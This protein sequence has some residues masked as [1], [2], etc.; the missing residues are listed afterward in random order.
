MRSN[1]V[2]RVKD[3]FGLTVNYRQYNN[4]AHWQNVGLNNLASSLIVRVVR[5]FSDWS[6]SNIWRCFFIMFVCKIE[7]K[8]PPTTDQYFS[9]NH[10][11]KNSCLCFPLSLR[12]I[13]PTKTPFWVDASLFR[14]VTGSCLDLYPTPVYAFI[15]VGVSEQ[16]FVNGAALCALHFEPNLEQ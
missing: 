16:S 6:P 3:L 1:H 5:Q 13:F 14:L 15:A 4:D 2:P 10:F 7:R 12:N 9:Q 8:T 11:P